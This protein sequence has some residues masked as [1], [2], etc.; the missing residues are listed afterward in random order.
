MQKVAVFATIAY[1]DTAPTILNFIHSGIFDR[2][3]KLKLV[4]VESGC[5]WIPFALEAAEWHID[6]MV[7]AA[8]KAL[9]RRPTEYFKD[10]IY[11]TF[12]F[13][14]Q[15]VK[16]F[17]EEVGA[18]NLLFLTDYPHPTALYSGWQERLARVLAKLEPAARRR[19]M[20]DNA[21]ELYKLPIPVS[22]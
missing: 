13:E 17:V 14:D 8:A 22:A 1:T 3:P 5:G 16:H 6:E 9:K 20:Q 11:A 4:S 21:V 15:G 19:V 7:P 18:N 10:H 12:W 2:Y